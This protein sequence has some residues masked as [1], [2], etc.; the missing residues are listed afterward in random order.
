MGPG[1][2]HLRSS[3]GPANLHHVDLDV[4][5]LHQ[6]LAGDLLAGHQKRLGGL[7]PCADAQ[8]DVSVS[9]VQPGDHAGENLMLLG[10][11]LLVH[12]ASL[13][14]PK[15]LND[16]LL[17]VT[18]GN[19]AKVRVVHG[20]VDHVANF[21][22]GGK[23]FG[24]LQ[25]H[26][27]EGVH[28]VFL[29]HHVFLDK[30]LKRPALHIHVHDHVIHLILAIPFIGG[31]QRLDNFLQHKGLGDVP[32]LFNHLKRGENLIAIH[33]D[34]LLLLLASHCLYSFYDMIRLLR[35]FYLAAK[36][37]RARRRRFFR[38]TPPAGAPTRCPPYQRS[39]HCRRC[40][41]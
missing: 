4:H 17:T 41:R 35:P 21:V 29:V 26:F 28:V 22:F 33:A 30:H 34:E 10:V 11:E 39:S 1:D 16:H 5:S 9:R 8:R 18:G 15:A 20:D 32:L 6:L 2:Q 19:A 40:A 27:V 37:P 36:N 31:D 24:L 38:R 23:L 13:G 7:G 25:G 3:G 12:H 14:L